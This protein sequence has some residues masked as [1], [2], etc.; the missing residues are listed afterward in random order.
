[1]PAPHSLMVAEILPF[2]SPN[3]RCSPSAIDAVSTKQRPKSPHT[4]PKAPSATVRSEATQLSISVDRHNRTIGTA[5][6][7][8]TLE[9]GKIDSLPTPLAGFPPAN[10]I[11]DCTSDVNLAAE[12]QSRRQG[13]DANPSSVH[14]LLGVFRE[15]ILFSHSHPPVPQFARLANQDHRTP[16]QTRVHCWGQR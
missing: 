2:P 11:N 1:M 8:N 4:M 6:C 3:H 7:L 9:S 14:L 12:T 15:R 10:G 13:F 5:Y 16:S